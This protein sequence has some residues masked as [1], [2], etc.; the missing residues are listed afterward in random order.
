MYYIFISWQTYFFRE[1][2]LH[3]RRSAL[4]IQQ[5]N[6]W[7]QIDTKRLTSA[8]NE[9]STQHGF[10]EWEGKEEERK[11]KIYN[12]KYFTTI[13]ILI[14]VVFALLWWNMPVLCAHGRYYKHCEWPETNITKRCLNLNQT[15]HKCIMLDWLELTKH[16]DTWTKLT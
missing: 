9:T 2:S 11:R 1:K 14:S 8:N 5:K 3:L 10:Y 4:F 15:Y 12:K 7:P 16:S 6:S 13:I